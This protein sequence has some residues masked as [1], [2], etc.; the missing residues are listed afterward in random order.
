MGWLIVGA[1]LIV[2]VVVH[3]SVRLIALVARGILILGL[4]VIRLASS[5]LR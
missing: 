2:G 4:A 1:V 3:A 5:L